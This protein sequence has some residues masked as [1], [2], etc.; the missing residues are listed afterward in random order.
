MTLESKSEIPSVVRQLDVT[1]LHLLRPSSTRANLASI[2]GDVLSCLNCSKSG[3]TV[4]Y[5]QRDGYVYKRSLNGQ[6]R[7]SKAT[8]CINILWLPDRNGKRPC[9]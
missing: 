7:R 9:P 8:N 1:Q 3:S 5:I 6:H 4:C 2:V